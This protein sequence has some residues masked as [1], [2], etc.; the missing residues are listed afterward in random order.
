MSQPDASLGSGMTSF[1]SIGRMASRGSRLAT[2]VSAFAFA[3]SAVSFY[4][5]VLKTPK[6]AMHVPPVIQ[7]ARDGETE[8]FAIPLTVSNDGARTG[9]VLSLDLDVTNPA[10]GK[11]MAFYS[12]FFGDHPQKPDTT[13]RSFAP[14]SIPGRATFTDTIR[15]YPKGRVLPHLID[16]KGSFSFRLTMHTA[17]PAGSGLV[18]RLLGSEP[19]PIEFVRTLPWISEQQLTFRRM[20]I[21]M[22][23]R[24]WDAPD[25]AAPEKAKDAGNSAGKAVPKAAAQ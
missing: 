14:L 16:N 10:D 5:T 18:E 19:R 7:Y 15:F 24:A 8:V 9:T 17:K 4:E 3:F 25:A 11:T 6:L 21:S 22:H 20:T 23:D 12:A 1:P 2:I 13:N